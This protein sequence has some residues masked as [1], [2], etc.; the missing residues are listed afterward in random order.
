MGE[1]PSVPGLHDRSFFPL[2]AET[3]A[4]TLSADYV[5]VGEF[6]PDE[7]IVA[8]AI[9]AQGRIL[10]GDEYRLSGTPCENVVGRRECVFT[11][12]VQGLFP[13]DRI[14]A[15][16][17]VESYVGMPLFDAKGT[18]LGLL[19]AMW[20]ASLTD[21]EPARSMLALF[22]GRAAHEI[23]R[24]RAD[25]ALRASEARFRTL[26][27]LSPMGVFEADERGFCTYLSTQWE[28]ITGRRNEQLLGFGWADFMHPDDIAHSRA[29]WRRSCLQRSPYLDEFRVVLET[30][31]TRW[32]RAIGRRLEGDETRPASYVGCIEDITDRK[33]AELATTGRR[34]TLSPRVHGQQPGHCLH[35]GRGRPPGLRES[36][37]LKRFQ[38]APKTSLETDFEMFDAELAPQVGRQ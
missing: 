15:D 26:C 29:T 10:V 1:L 19:A 37:I 31:E 21:A 33:H 5:M 18:A 6:R 3:L 16:W 11:A 12:N 27:Q 8:P 9:Y 28:A 13:Q 22:A 4:K 20:T 38:R 14:L 23:E 36:A 2:L 25:E 17:G 34:G 24:A 32:A 35:E 7:E 30:G